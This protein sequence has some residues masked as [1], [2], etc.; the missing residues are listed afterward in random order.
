M[1]QE[2]INE[3]IEACQKRLTDYNVQLEALSKKEEVSEEDQAQFDY[4][5]REISSITEEI[6]SLLD[7]L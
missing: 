6:E 4:I 3:K 7:L 5:L 2:E 1:T